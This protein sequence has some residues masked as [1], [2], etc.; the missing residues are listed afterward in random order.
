MQANTN[1]APA[2][3]KT[4]RRI[5]DA[6]ERIAL[7]QE[8]QTLIF[9]VLLEGDIAPAQQPEPTVLLTQAGPVRLG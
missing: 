2:T 7:A 9:Q 3:E 6:L 5:A 8:A 1:T 4:A